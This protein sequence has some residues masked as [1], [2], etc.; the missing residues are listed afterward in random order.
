MDI[1]M[2]HVDGL[3]LTRIVR[4]RPGGA[5]LV[6]VAFTAYA[7][8]GDEDKMRAAGCDN[9]IAKPIDVTTFA[10]QVRAFLK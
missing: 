5:Q 2:P 6:V 1:Q 3:A 10:A 7:M 4:A 8:R 9:Y